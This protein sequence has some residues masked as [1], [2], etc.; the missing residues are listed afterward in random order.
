MFITLLLLGC[1]W[2]I[3]KTNLE[4]KEQILLIFLIPVQV[5][6]CVANLMILK[7]DK[8]DTASVWRRYFIISDLICGVSLLVPV[9]W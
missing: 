3:L 5:L 1:G 4:G 2:S 9:F 8:G 6:A 7:G